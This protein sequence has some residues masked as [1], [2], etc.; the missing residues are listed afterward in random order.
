MTD[1]EFIDESM[2][3]VTFSDGTWFYQYIREYRKEGMKRSKRVI[4]NAF[5]YDQCDL[6][7]KNL[8]LLAFNIQIMSGKHLERFKDIDE[9]TEE[10]RNEWLWYVV[11][12]SGMDPR[13]LVSNDHK[14]VKRK[15]KF[16]VRMYLKEIQNGQRDWWSGRIINVG[17]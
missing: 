14:Y 9:V 16:A 4:A 7:D 15:L 13:I 5:R 8:V 2:E 3:Q 10:F 11:M 1:L 17:E 6:S 12:P